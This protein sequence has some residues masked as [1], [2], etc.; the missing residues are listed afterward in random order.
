M[1]RQRYSY[2]TKAF[3]SIDKASSVQEHYISSEIQLN[4]M[5]NNYA[6]AYI[7]SHTFEIFLEP[8]NVVPISYSSL[9]ITLA[10]QETYIK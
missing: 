4:S 2:I 8:I 9:N 3:K 7:L 6:M 1:P 10:E 5:F